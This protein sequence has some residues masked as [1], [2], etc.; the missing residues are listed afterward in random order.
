MPSEGRWQQTHLFQRYL[1]AQGETIDPVFTTLPVPLLPPDV[2]I[3][4]EVVADSI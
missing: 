3:T 1:V 2:A 4:H